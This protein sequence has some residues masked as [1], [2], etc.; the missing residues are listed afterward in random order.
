MQ[1]CTIYKDMRCSSEKTAHHPSGDTILR[2][3]YCSRSPLHVNKQCAFFAERPNVLRDVVEST[4]RT[5]GYRE[6]VLKSGRS[7]ARS[8]PGKCGN[9]AKRR[10]MRLWSVQDAVGEIRKGWLRRMRQ[11]QPALVAPSLPRLLLLL[12]LQDRAWR[13]SVNLLAFCSSKL[14]ASPI[15]TYLLVV[16]LARKCDPDRRRNHLLQQARDLALVV[17]L[18]P[19][20]GLAEIVL[21][22]NCDVAFLLWACHWSSWSNAGKCEVAIDTRLHLISQPAPVRGFQHTAVWDDL[23]ASHPIGCPV[24]RRI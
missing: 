2:H 7:L 21:G 6:M 12:R 5:A 11:R 15:R 14:S 24:S 8:N 10:V 17:D 19:E 3:V 18:R 16:D 23:S 22:S 4:Q 9:T 13:R 20:R 1:C